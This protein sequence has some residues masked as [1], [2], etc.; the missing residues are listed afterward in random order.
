VHD[1]SIQGMTFVTLAVNCIVVISLLFV[2][3]S[4]F[5]SVGDIK[6]KI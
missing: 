6:E 3:R 2:C 4:I 1:F 5:L